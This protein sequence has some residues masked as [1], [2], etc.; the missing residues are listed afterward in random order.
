M[1]SV[2]QQQIKAY[3]IVPGNGLEKTKRLLTRPDP[4]GML[5]QAWVKAGYG[6][7]KAIGLGQ[8]GHD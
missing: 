3:R 4:T 1:Y 5:N 7:V 6:G 8:H 2:V